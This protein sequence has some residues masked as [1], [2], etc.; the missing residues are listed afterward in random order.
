MEKANQKL[1]MQGMAYEVISMV[2]VRENDNEYQVIAKYNG[3]CK[4]KQGTYTTWTYWEHEKVEDCSFAWGHY[5]LTFKEA[6]E[7][8][9]RKI[10]NNELP[11]FKKNATIQ[12]MDDIVESLKTGGLDDWEENI[13]QGKLEGMLDAMYNIDRNFYLELDSKYREFC[14]W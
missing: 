2:K 11:Q 5:D 7:V 3:E 14:A 8:V 12:W 4:F 13:L 9:A 1:Q 10:G 6:Q